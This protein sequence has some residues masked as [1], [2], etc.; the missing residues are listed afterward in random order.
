MRREDNWELEG[1]ARLR[2]GNR[3]WI[4]SGKILSRTSRSSTCSSL[5][6]LARY[7]GYFEVQ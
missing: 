1:M 2:R 7:H 4:S 5:P 6:I 3:P